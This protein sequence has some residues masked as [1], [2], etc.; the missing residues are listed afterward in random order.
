MASGA[1]ASAARTSEQAAVRRS[2][3]QRRIGAC[4]SLLEHG[5]VRTGAT[6]GGGNRRPTA[7]ELLN[8]GVLPNQT[9]VP[10]AADLAAR[11]EILA[12]QLSESLK[13]LARVAY[14]YRW[15]WAPDGPAVFRDINPH[16]WALSW[17]NPVRF[18]RDLWPG[19]QEACD[20]NP[21]LRARIDAL[22][23]EVDGDLARPP[24]P[25]PGIEGPVAFFCAEFGFH[26]SMPIYSGGLGVLA[27]DIL[28]EASDQALPMV[29]VGLF[30]RRGY[31]RQR[32]DLSGR[33][34]EFW[35][36]NDP[37]S[38]PMAR[39]S[40][41][42]GRPLRLEVQVDARRI[43][44]EVWRV[45]VG[46]VPLLLL[47]AELPEND[48]VSRW[49]TARLYEGNRAVRLAQYGLLGIGGARVL[50]ALGIEPGAIHLNEGHPALAPLELA[51][52][53]VERGA[54]FAEAL[55]SVRARTVFTTHTPVPA[56]NETYS[57]AD[58]LEA[59]GDL[60]Y[61]LGIDDEEFLGLCRVDPGNGEEPP[62]MTPLA[63]RLSHRRNGVSRL[64]GEVARTMWRPMFPGLEPSEV[65]ITHVTNGAHLASFL[66]EP[67][68]RLLARH[69]GPA[70]WERPADAAAWEGVRAIPNAE[71]WAARREARADLVDYVRAR[72]QVERLQ[73]GEQI[74][75]VR[76]I[77]SGLD[78][79]AL[80][81]GF[82]RRFATYKRVYLLTH[83]PERTARILSGSPPVQLL[84][85][86]KAHPN[87]DGGKDVLQHL[88][89]FKRGVPA[90]ADRLVIIEDYDLAVARHLVSGC[91]VWINLP[92]RP[93]EASGTSGM[94]ATFN[95]ALQLSVLDGWWDE[96]YD[97][98]N[99]W[100]IASEE[101]G[102][103]DLVD[104][105]DAQRFYDLLEQEVIPL[106]YE[107]DAD[108]IPERWC[109]MVK[110][111][112]V[113]CGPT[114]SAT[115]MVDEY[116]ERIYPAG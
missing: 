108:G 104:A 70:W 10:G 82:A 33:Q 92:R 6:G 8:D 4:G 95:G 22:V 97:G 61:R 113:S 47:D 45:D 66:G 105:H 80:T 50:D 98:D 17:A 96:G 42:D 51:T 74:G 78:P 99:G 14:N 52:M 81:L 53:R 67:M 85:A 29:G 11:T 2:V 93:L 103:L 31:F 46:R 63:I 87:D 112:L 44:F 57:P 13:P 79:D 116:V 12:E 21:E 86:G 62:G 36:A 100:A 107:R 55:E 68:W 109:E 7:L 34:Q 23:A 60:A 32:L 3:T 65:P 54:S 115:R 90:I 16:R 75:Y 28:K 56:G 58:F 35:S 106:F 1:D 84:V 89:G 88:Y 27:G 64:H 43:A 18:L 41:L 24:R 110:R 114:F 39:V 102:D 111:A 15:S 69:L 77:E 91:D 30:Y 38:L 101:D 26:V 94:K 20:N 25:R 48:A 72:S 37:K 49:T 59:Y 76:A 71:L 19:T 9:F 40:G 83:D 5:R 73:R